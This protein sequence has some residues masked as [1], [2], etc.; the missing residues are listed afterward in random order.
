MIFS[1]Q[2]TMVW[3]LIEYCHFFRLCYL[4]WQLFGRFFRS[5]CVSSTATRPE[6]STIDPLPM[7]FICLPKQ[8]E[9]IESNLI[10]RYNPMF[11]LR[12]IKMTILYLPISLISVYLLTPDLI[13]HQIR[14]SLQLKRH[15]KRGT[16]SI[17]RSLYKYKLD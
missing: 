17:V 5:K 8:T 9:L 15:S 12:F 1:K 2:L 11:P 13:P 7:F 3:S 16:T 10:F 6:D 14:N 4:V